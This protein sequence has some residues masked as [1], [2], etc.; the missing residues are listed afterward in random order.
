MK[1]KTMILMVVAVACGLGAS[2]M[3]SK[4]LADRNNKPAEVQ[5]VP[6][7]VAKQRIAGWQPIKE[8]EKLFEIK[9]FPVDVA[10]KKAIGNFADLKDQRL[11]KPLDESKAVTMEDLLTNEQRTVADQLQPGQRAVSIKVTTEGVVSGFV[12]PGSRVDVICTTRGGLEA[13]SNVILQNM[14]VLAADQTPERNPEQKS[15]L[16]QTV[17]LAAT[18]AEATRLAL[19]SEIGMLRLSLKNQGDMTNVNHAVVK[20][21]DL[22]KPLGNSDGRESGAPSGTAGAGGTSQLPVLPAD[23]KGPK[24]EEPPV[25]AKQRRRHVMTIINGT[26]REKAVFTEGEDEDVAGGEGGEGGDNKEEKPV[27]KPKPA[28]VG[29]AGKAKPKKV[30]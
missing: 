30:Q 21:S 2:Y 7:L 24:V 10:P 4:L 22:Q 20:A 23:D 26:Q 8:P 19:A 18:P 3:T 17:T 9:M 29:P 16:A 6:V 27:E 25:V 1:P 13:T 28:P 5:T 11:N 12:L 15:I 14:L